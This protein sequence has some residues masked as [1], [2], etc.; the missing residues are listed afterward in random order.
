MLYLGL[1]VLGRL[2]TPPRLKSKLP[3]LGLEQQRLFHS[4]GK[5]CE[6]ARCCAQGWTSDRLDIVPS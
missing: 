6:I 1:G 4:G 3:S 5:F 2:Y